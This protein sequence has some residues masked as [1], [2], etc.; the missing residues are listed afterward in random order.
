VPFG[1]HLRAVGEHPALGGWDPSAAPALEWSEGDTWRCELSGL[2]AEENSRLAFKLVV[3]HGD[4]KVADSDVDGGLAGVDA[5]FRAWIEENW[6][7]T[8]KGAA[9]EATETA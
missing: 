9:A 8:K 3:V 7:R 6:P 5:A 1:S 4:E 2:P